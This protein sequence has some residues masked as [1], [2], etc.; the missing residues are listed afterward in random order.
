[1]AANGSRRISLLRAFLGAAGHYWLLVF[2]HARRTV[3]RCARCAE[4]VPDSVL[5]RGAVETLAE[6]RG[7]LEGA[8]AFAVYAPRRSR[9]SVIE[10]LVAFQAMF[11][12]ADTLAEQPAAN[13]AANARALHQALL[14]A[15]SST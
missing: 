13:P 12:F 2:P 8:A 5:R 9:R 14:D 10:A 6:E 1:M 15:L 3:L 11:D 7:N 4:T